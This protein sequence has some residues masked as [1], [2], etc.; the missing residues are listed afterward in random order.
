MSIG[1]RFV[2]YI[3]KN[4]KFDFREY[5]VHD[6][7]STWYPYMGQEGVQ[8]D[9]V[10]RNRVN[11]PKMWNRFSNT[12]RNFIDES[13][14][15]SFCFSCSVIPRVQAGCNDAPDFTN[16]MKS[17]TTVGGTTV[18]QYTCQS[19]KYFKCT[20]RSVDIP[21]T[22]WNGSYRSAIAINSPAIKN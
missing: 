22:C 12:L 18:I 9:I 5:L 1:F 17:T 2:L 20:Y 4:F 21:N 10:V 11:Q 14:L 16:A 6:L 3:A 8:Y 19:K 15:S 13:I 7:T